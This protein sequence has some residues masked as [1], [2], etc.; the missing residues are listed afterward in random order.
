V[1]LKG[2]KVSCFEEVLVAAGYD[3]LK[4]GMDSSVIEVTDI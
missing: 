3:C 4:T 2:K 1:H